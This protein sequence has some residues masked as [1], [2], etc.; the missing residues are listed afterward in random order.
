ML[1]NGWC[2]IDQW[3]NL[4]MGRLITKAMLHTTGALVSST[5]RLC[6]STGTAV[7]IRQE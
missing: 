5:K 7:R 2:E 6:A 1:M 4:D 3:G